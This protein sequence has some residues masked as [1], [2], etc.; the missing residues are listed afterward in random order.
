MVRT[1]TAQEARQR[2]GQLLEGT[3]RGDEVI[4]ER[5]GKPMGVVISPS[6][7]ADLERRREE[8]KQRLFEMVDELREQNKD[9]DPDEIQRAVDAAVAAVRRERRDRRQTEGHVQAASDAGAAPE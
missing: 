7:Y 3:R 4:I 6:R 1:V 8:A 5:A 9:A 2:L